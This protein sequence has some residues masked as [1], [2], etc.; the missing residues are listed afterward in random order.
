MSVI[1]EAM[2]L[3]RAALGVPC[4]AVHP[5]GAECAMCNRVEVG[6]YSASPAYLVERLEVIRRRPLPPLELLRFPAR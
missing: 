5:P 1:D 3:A 2:I 6:G 4:S